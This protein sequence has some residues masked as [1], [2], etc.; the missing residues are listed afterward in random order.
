MQK[1]SEKIDINNFYYTNNKKN[2]DGI[3]FHILS[4]RFFRVY[5]AKM[6][7]SLEEAFEGNEITEE[8]KNILCTVD[9]E[10]DVSI[11]KNGCGE[12]DSN[13]NINT[14]KDFIVRKLALVL[15]S[16]CNMRCKYC[17]ANYGMYNYEKEESMSKEGLEAILNY[18]VNNFNSIGS[19]QFFG[20]EP[21]MKTELIYQT[22]DYFE[23]LLIKGKIKKLPLFGIVS[24]GVYMPSKLVDYFKKYNFYVTISL[25]GPKDINDKLRIDCTGEGQ[26]A[27][28]YKNIL[29]LKE[30]RIDG[31]GFECTYTAEHIRQGISLVDLVKYFEK[32]FTSSI[33]HVA[34]ISIENDHPL[35]LVPYTKQYVK[36]VEELVDFTFDKIFEEKKL[37]ST[38][39]IF[40]VI[41]RLLEQAKQQTICP[42]GVQTFSVA[43]DN[44][45]SPCFMY[46]SKDDISYGE[47]GD[48]ADDILLKAYAFDKNIN[49]KALVKNC[50]E[51]FARNVC[52]SCL[53][54]FEIEENSAEIT[55]P[56]FCKTIKAASLQTLR[57]MAEIKGNESKWV[58]FNR[59]LN[60]EK[61]EE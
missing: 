18:F 9:T 53:G 58:E 40:G 19:I 22:V 20:G 15:T 33:V 13:K 5:D 39:I 31:L 2:N 47:V 7:Q 56:I 43:H 41:T 28:I 60:K 46:T 51:C 45:I 27:K 4:G 37:Y 23:K 42:A 1:I 34:P 3:L 61:N 55:N 24:N 32:E 12:C 57:H 50:Q 17:Y 29:R 8:A 25:D 21:T 52:S 49:N 36:Y 54:S 16:S 14:A 30:A 48:N 26:F 6:Q 10:T 35:S 59:F 38:N 44:K 11:C